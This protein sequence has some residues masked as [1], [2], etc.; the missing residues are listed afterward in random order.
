M[1]LLIAA[2]S[3]LLLAGCGND[4]G[5]GGGSSAKSCTKDVFSY[6]THMDGLADYD[7]RDM[8]FDTEYVY[9]V[10]LTTGETCEMDIVTTGANC[11]GTITTTNATYVGGG[12][13]DP[14]CAT[15]DGVTSY[16]INSSNLLTACDDGCEQYE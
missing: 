3:T 15:L 13:G 2:A 4:S 14:G 10:A 11:S 9:V 5:G 12:S 1:K 16:S 7:L 8:E 6:W